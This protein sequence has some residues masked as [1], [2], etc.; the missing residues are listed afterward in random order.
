M[1]R[2]EEGGGV[3]V[4]GEREAKAST[5][6][7]DRGDVIVRVEENRFQFWRGSLQSHQH[8]FVARCHL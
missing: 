6:W 7:K 4:E 2:R 3:A 5:H 1:K 8:H